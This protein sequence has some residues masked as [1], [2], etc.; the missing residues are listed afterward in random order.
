MIV[1][2]N[3]LTAIHKLDT[4]QRNIDKKLPTAFW[5]ECVR[6]ASGRWVRYEGHSSRYGVKY[7]RGHQPMIDYDNLGEVT[8]LKNSL[9]TRRK[10]YEGLCDVTSMDLMTFTFWLEELRRT[11]EYRQVDE[12]LHQRFATTAHTIIVK[13]EVVKIAEKYNDPYSTLETT[14]PVFAN[15]PLESLP[16]DKPEGGLIEH[17]YPT[18]DYSGAYLEAALSIL[19]KLISEKLDNQ[20]YI[21]EIAKFYQLLINLHY[22]A[23]MNASLYMNMAN[24]LLTVGGIDGIEN[25]I[26]DFAALRLQPEN[27]QK[28]FYDEVLM[29]SR[30]TTAT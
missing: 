22:F 15:F 19:K 24:G 17:H 16:H 2:L 9:A 21:Y 4:V 6:D 30:L 12:W 8:Y 26:I 3:I 23:A 28:Y 27:F 14:G 1:R 25:G 5:L 18:L 11:L 29:N 7:F 10:F 13:E 20:E